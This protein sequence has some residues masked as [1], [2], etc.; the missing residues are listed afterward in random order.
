MR[1]PGFRDAWLGLK[2]YEL[3][4]ETEM[5]KARALIGTHVTGKPWSAVEPLFRPDHPENA[6]LRQATSYWEMAASFVNRGILHPDVFL[7]TCGESLFTYAAFEPHL[8]K[9][10]VARE[11][12]LLQME[13]AIRAH[14][15][16]A[17]R[18]AAIR[19]QLAPK[20]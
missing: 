17:A 18:L 15:P 8:P 9:I 4:R 2:L 7:D 20:A 6:H 16:L 12:F 11:R 5:R 10:R 19:A 3:R 1:S 14:P 13:T